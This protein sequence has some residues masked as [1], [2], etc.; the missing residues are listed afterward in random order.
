MQGASQNDLNILC[1]RLL[2]VAQVLTSDSL[3]EAQD[4]LRVS[5]LPKMQD[6]IFKK[7]AKSLYKIGLSMQEVKCLW[8]LRADV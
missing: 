4:T 6:R 5:I 3:E 8:A 1:E 2:Q 7:S